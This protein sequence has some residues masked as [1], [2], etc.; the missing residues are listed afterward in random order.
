M[1]H[2]G[3]VAKLKLQMGDVILKISIYSKRERTV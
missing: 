2:G 3:I 1:E